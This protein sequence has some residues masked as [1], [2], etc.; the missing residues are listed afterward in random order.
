VRRAILPSKN[1]DLV[2]DVEGWTLS[3]WF[4]MIKAIFFDA[5]G[6]LFYLTRTVGHHYALVGRSR[7]YPRCASARSRVLFSLEKDAVP[8]G[9]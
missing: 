6:T 4:L 7:T 5:V 9:Y 2:F 8:R 1:D 3:V